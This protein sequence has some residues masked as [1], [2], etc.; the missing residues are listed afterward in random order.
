MAWMAAVSTHA[1]SACFPEDVIP[2]NRF[3][4]VRIETSLGA[5]DIELN[6]L[7]A[8]ASSNNFLRYVLDGHYDG[9]VFHRVVPGF[10]IQGGGYTRDLEERPLREPI[11]NESGNGLKN[12]AMS[13]A[14]ARFDDP[15]S[16]TSQWFV[17]LG[18]NESLDPGARHWGYA[19]FGSV[20]AGQEVVEA[21]AAVATGYSQGLDAQD[22]PL[23]P[24]LIERAYVVDSN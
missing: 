7:R 8:P 21:I 2:D 3:P 23:I 15:H 6:R 22:V 10:V 13:V 14:M 9:T 1:A 11:V 12:V 17:N 20:I 18:A 24:V 16:A 19:V 4:T 5:F